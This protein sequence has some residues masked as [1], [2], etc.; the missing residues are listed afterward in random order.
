MRLLFA[1]TLFIFTVV[2]LPCFAQFYDY[3]PPTSGPGSELTKLRVT[4]RDAVISKQACQQAT[5]E[6]SQQASTYCEIAAKDEADFKRLYA[7]H[8]GKNIPGVQALCEPT[9]P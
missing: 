5:Q 4:F 3:Q 6:A 7:A 8:R 1:S 2:T 9:N